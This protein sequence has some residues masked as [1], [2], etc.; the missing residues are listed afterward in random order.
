VT[1]DCFTGRS[2]AKPPHGVES[3]GR[4]LSERFLD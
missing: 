4:I 1:I 2:L 3:S